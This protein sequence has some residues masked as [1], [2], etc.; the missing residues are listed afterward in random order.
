MTKIA[1]RR[2]GPASLRAPADHDTH[3][4]V[5]RRSLR[6]LVPPYESIADIIYEMDR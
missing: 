1:S 3:N 5:G 4:M 2:V 6:D